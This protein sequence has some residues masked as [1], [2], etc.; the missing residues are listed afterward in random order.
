[1]P[2]SKRKSRRAPL[3]MSVRV[4]AAEFRNN[5]MPGV[6]LSTIRRWMR[7]KKSFRKIG[8]TCTV[9]KGDAVEIINNIFDY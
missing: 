8:G 4:T 7:R 6:S 9:S 5:Y 1:M 2:A 3:E